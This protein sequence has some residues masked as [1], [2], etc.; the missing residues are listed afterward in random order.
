MKDGGLSEKTCDTYRWLVGPKEIQA[1]CGHSS[2]VTTLDTYGPSSTLA[3]RTLLTGTMRLSVGFGSRRRGR[4]R[5]VWG[6]AAVIQSVPQTTP[7]DGDE[8][9]PR[10]RPRF[11]PPPE[12]PGPCDG[13][14]VRSSSACC[15][16]SLS[17]MRIP[18]SQL[19]RT[20]GR[21]LP[22]GGRGSSQPRTPLGYERRTSRPRTRGGHHTGPRAAD[23][24]ASSIERVTQTISGDAGGHMTRG[25]TLCTA[26]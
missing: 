13:T 21:P 18:A 7:P 24:G 9:P 16:S 15:S 22:S 12:G 2:I 4:P 8:D 3:R 1:M 26:R 6:W 19:N 10:H 25:G 20:E 14:L 17:S 11:D 23:V 5:E